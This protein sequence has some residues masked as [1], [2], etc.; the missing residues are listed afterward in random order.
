MMIQSKR[1]CAASVSLQGSHLMSA[2]LGKRFLQSYWK[3]I[4]FIHLLRGLHMSYYFILIIILWGRT[5]IISVLTL[6][7]WKLREINLAK[8]AQPPI[9]QPRVQSRESLTPTF[10]LSST[11]PICFTRMVVGS[12]MGSLHAA[13]LR[14]G[15]PKLSVLMRILCDL[16]GG[17]WSCISGRC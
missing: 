12:S 4:I 6:R 10:M 17:D 3:L 8:L 11:A 2:D 15:V 5:I 7:R 14:F 1:S 9:D 16:F 13:D